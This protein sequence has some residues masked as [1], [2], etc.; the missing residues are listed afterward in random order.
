ML[1]VTL[2]FGRKPLYIHA[3]KNISTLSLKRILICMKWNISF[4]C[5]NLQCQYFTLFWQLC[6]KNMHCTVTLVRFDIWVYRLY[7]TRQTSQFIVS[8]QRRKHSRQW[9]WIW[10]EMSIDLNFHH[11]HVIDFCVDWTAVFNLVSAPDSS[12]PQF[13]MHLYKALVCFSTWVL[14]W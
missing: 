6:C 10:N 4:V 9:C 5:T 3:I 11:E 8:T 7:G 14:L 13:S 12:F 1:R 2:D